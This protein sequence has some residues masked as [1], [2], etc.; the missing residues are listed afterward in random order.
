MDWTSLL[1]VLGGAGAGFINAIAGGGSALVIPVLMISGV[2]A[3]VANGTNRLVVGVN[4]ITATSTFHV[5]GVRPWG[6]SPMLILVIVA[7]TVLG[8]SFATGVSAEQLEIA[9]GIVFVG[10]AL[11][12]GLKPSFLEPGAGRWFESK[13]VGYFGIF[14]CGIYGGVLQ[15]GV[16]V[17]LLLVL[18]NL[19]GL[20]VVRS[21]AMKSMMICVYSILVVIVFDSAGLVDWSRGG[22]LVLGGL[23]GSSLGARAVITRGREFIRA[24]T[25]TALVLAAAKCFGLFD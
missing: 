19:F 2:D 12:L 23:V 16:G 14:L 18:V 20:D 22:W 6:K 21:N 4:A 1:L 13:V 7:G 9:F 5:Q 3:S 11:L 24:V 8:A 15:A 10:L 25:V 17:P